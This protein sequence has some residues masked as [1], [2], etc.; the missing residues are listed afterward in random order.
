MNMQTAEKVE[1]QGLL[2]SSGGLFAGQV[3]GMGTAFLSYLVVARLL[4]AEDFGRFMFLYAVLAYMA[5]FFDA[6]ASVAAGRLLALSNDQAEQQQ[7]VGAWLNLFGVLSLAYAATLLLGAL[8]IDRMF[9]FHVARILG[10]CALPAIGFPLHNALREILQGLG[11]HPRLLFLYVAPWGGFLIGLG[12]L[13]LSGQ[14]SLLT[15]GLLLTV[16][17]FVTGVVVLLTLKPRFS[18]QRTLNSPVWNETKRFG[19]HAYLARLVGTGTYQ[20]DTPLIAFFVRDPTS[21][22]FYGLAKGIAA[23]IALLTSSMGVASYRRLASS[24]RLPRETVWLGMLLLLAACLGVLLVGRPVVLGLLSKSYAGVLPLLY[25][26]VGVAFVQGCYQ[27]PNQFLSAQGE[28]VILRTM[29][30]WFSVANLILNFSLIP[31]WGAMGATIASGGAYLLWL[32]L[33]IFYYNRVTRDKVRPLDLENR[34]ASP[35]IEN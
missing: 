13:G 6:G 23:P 10:L 25:V 24:K 5:M 12:A 17:F 33:C 7:V 3:I 4:G 31:V 34:H 26:W 22:G 29:A 9:Q 28:G 16:S 32:V 15:V 1:V 21:V 8:W 20:L 27:L 19:F 30:L 18:G 11:A 2:L 35:Q 14:V